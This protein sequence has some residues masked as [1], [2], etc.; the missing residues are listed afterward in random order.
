M[1]V[2]DADCHTIE[3]ED[4]WAFMT[5]EDARYRPRVLAV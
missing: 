2:I 5:G 1:P 3:T 4:T